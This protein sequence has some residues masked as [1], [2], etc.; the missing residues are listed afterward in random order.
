[1]QAMFLHVGQPQR[2]YAVNSDGSVS[3]ISFTSSVVD[4][5]QPNDEITIPP[6]CDSPLPQCIRPQQNGTSAVY[7]PNEDNSSLILLE[8]EGETL[9]TYNIISP[10]VFNDFALL[11]N[12]NN[13]PLLI[14]CRLTDNDVCVFCVHI[15]TQHY[16]W[17]PFICMVQNRNAKVMQLVDIAIAK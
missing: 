15:S 1:M 12:F 5:L 2:F 11:S 17:L 3:N 7:I 14:A 10:C 8:I 4:V 6:S 13:K 9:R 16:I